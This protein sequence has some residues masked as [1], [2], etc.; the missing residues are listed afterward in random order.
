MPEEKQAHKKLIP[1]AEQIQREL[2]NASSIDDFFRKRGDHGEAVRRY[3]DGN[4][5]S[6]VNQ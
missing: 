1:T 6:R 2:D 4:D 5:E 3:V